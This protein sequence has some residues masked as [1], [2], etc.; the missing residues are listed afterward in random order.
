MKERG[1]L[2]KK[3]NLVHKK[4]AQLED[5]VDL[6]GLQFYICISHQTFATTHSNKHLKNIL[7]CVCSWFSSLNVKVILG[8]HDSCLAYGMN[9]I[10]LHA[11]YREM[12]K[13]TGNQ[14]SKPNSIKPIM[15]K[16][17]NRCHKIQNSMFQ[18]IFVKQCQLP[19]ETPMEKG[20]TLIISLGDVNYGLLQHLGCSG[21]NAI[22]F[23]HARK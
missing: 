11:M 23:C 3:S 8:K 1:E 7:Q 21:Q 15:P 5:N 14:S 9:F 6:D 19:G 22:I 2:N 20:G 4:T 13:I 16:V 17:G 10:V 12:I 18:G